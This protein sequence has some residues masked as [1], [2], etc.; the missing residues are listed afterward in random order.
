[1]K[2]ISGAKKRFRFTGKNK[3]RFKKAFHSHIMTT[4]STKKKRHQRKPAILNKADT[5]R[6]KRMLPYGA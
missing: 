3:V 5:V 4:K 6:V 2:S 1:M